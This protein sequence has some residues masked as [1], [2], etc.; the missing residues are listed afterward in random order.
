MAEDCVVPSST[1]I[2]TQ[3]GLSRILGKSVTKERKFNCSA[4]NIYIHIHIKK[5]KKEIKNTF[6][7]H[8]MI[9]SS[10]IITQLKR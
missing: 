7:W 1:H 4:F 5:R 2:Y 10:I 6:R 9:V 8:Q 3:F